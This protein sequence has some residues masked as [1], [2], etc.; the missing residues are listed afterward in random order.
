MKQVEESARLV[1]I[2]LYI[3][4]C[5]VLCC[6]QNQIL[7]II[8]SVLI[9]LL[10]PRYATAIVEHILWFILGVKLKFSFMH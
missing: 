9:T 4:M 6:H 10:V 8:F 2:L 1:F 3:I 5:L 7:K